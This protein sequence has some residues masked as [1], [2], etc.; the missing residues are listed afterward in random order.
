MEQ[1]QGDHGSCD[2]G[3]GHAELIE[4][5]LGQRRDFLLDMISRRR[6]C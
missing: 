6:R 3:G 1:D 4:H 2:G 5:G